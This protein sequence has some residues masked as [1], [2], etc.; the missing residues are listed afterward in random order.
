M[1]QVGPV[2]LDVTVGLVELVGAVG[3]VEPVVKD[4]PMIRLRVEPSMHHLAGRAMA[5]TSKRF[6]SL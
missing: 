2:G 5:Q 4:A 3:L 1:E 6:T